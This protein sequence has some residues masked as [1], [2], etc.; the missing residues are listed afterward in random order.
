[1]SEKIGVIKLMDE[2]E[3]LK[4]FCNYVKHNNVVNTNIRITNIN[5]FFRLTIKDFEYNK[6]IYTRMAVEE[7]FNISDHIHEQ[8]MACWKIFI[9]YANDIR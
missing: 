3:V 5:P 2:Y 8:Y 1:M 4:D 7:I 9:D 6:K